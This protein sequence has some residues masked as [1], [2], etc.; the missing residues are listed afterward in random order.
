MPSAVPTGTVWY[1]QAMASQQPNPAQPDQ[2]SQLGA[3]APVVRSEN[4][5]PAASSDPIAPHLTGQALQAPWRLQYLES[6]D[7]QDK[8]RAAAASAGQPVSFMAAYWAAPERDVANHVVLRTAH[9]LILLNGY[10]Y[11]NG[12]LLVCLA[13]ARPRLL[14]YT[15]SQRAELWK[16]VDLATDL[17]ELT[18]QPQ[19][20][21]TG[22]NQGRAAGA[23]VPTHLHVHLI[24]RWGGDTNFITTVGRIRVIPA[25]LDAMTAR[26]RQVVAS[27]PRFTA[28]AAGTAQP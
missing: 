6:I 7:E 19:G 27:V 20:I 1:H 11:A 24:P 21:N 12:H 9:G 26:Y 28:A 15:E 10:P 22:I 13:E 16:L 23:G 8:Q 3:P 17:M 14:D 2:P 5:A 25:A 18:L 4:P